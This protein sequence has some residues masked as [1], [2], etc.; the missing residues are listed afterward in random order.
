MLPLPTVNFQSPLLLDM[1]IIHRITWKYQSFGQSDGC[2]LL[3]YK[4]KESHTS[5]NFDE[6]RN[7]C[8]S[9]LQI[10]IKALWWHKRC[11]MWI[12]FLKWDNID[13]SDRILN[14]KLASN[15]HVCGIFWI[16]CILSVFIGTD[17]QISYR[18]VYARFCRSFVHCTSVSVTLNIWSPIDSNSFPIAQNLLRQLWDA[19]EEVMVLWNRRSPLL[20]EISSF[21]NSAAK[22]FNWTGYKKNFKI[23]ASKFVHK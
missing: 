13:I 21:R 1:N 5:A 15:R 16:L 9:C 6:M 4:F 17:L 14:I 20:Y 12:Y 8:M 11:H 22:I 18:K 19:I 23:Q 10:E 2:L 7:I 3:M